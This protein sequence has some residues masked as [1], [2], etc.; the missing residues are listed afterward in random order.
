MTGR[1]NSAV[2][3]AGKIVAAD[4]NRLVTFDDSGRRTLFTRSTRVPSDVHPDADGGV[5]FLDSSGDQGEVKYVRDGR[6]RVVAVGDLQAL[7]LSTGAEGRV[8]VHGQARPHE[9]LPPSMSLLP[10]APQSRVSS[11]GRLAVEHADDRRPGRPVLQPRETAPVALRGLAVETRRELPFLV[12][13]GAD[14]TPH[15]AQGRAP[16]PAL[17]AAT[18][19][20]RTSSGPSNDTVD[21]GRACIVP[22][23]DPSTQVYQPHWK[24]VEWAAGNAVRGTLPQRP[25]NWKNSGLAAWSPQ[26]HFPRHELYRGAT[27]IAGGVIPPPIMLGILAQESNLWMASSHVIEG[28]TGNPLTGNFYGHARDPGN[29]GITDWTVRW[30]EADCGY[31]VGQITDWMNY[32]KPSPLPMEKAKAVAVDYATNIAAAVRILESKWNDLHSATEPM[33]KINNDNTDRIENWYFAVWSYNSGFYPHSNKYGN[34]PDG[35]PNNGAWGLGWFNNPINPRYPATRRMFMEI[36]A[37]A[38]HPQDWAYQ[39]KVIGWAAASITKTEGDSWQAGFQPAWWNPSAGN[40]APEN[41]AAAIPHG[42]NRQLFCLPSNECDPASAATPCRRADSKC[43]V[44]ESIT[45]KTDCNQRC[46]FWSYAYPAG[47]AEPPD[48]I[49]GGAADPFKPNCATTGLPGNALVVDDVA[50]NIPALRCDKTT[51]TNSGTLR[52]TFNEDLNRPGTYPARADFHQ[53]GNGFAG[54]QWFA[55]MRD[56]TSVNNASAMQ[57]TGTWTLNRELKQWARVLVHVPQRRAH[58]QQA[59]YTINLGNGTKKT[60]YI[61]QFTEENRWVSL[62]VYRFDG[63]PEV[64]LTTLALTRGGDGSDAV[65]WDAVAFQPL[66]AKPRHIVAALGDSYAS[67]EGAGTYYPE[68]DAN[69]GN[70][71]WNACRRSKNAWSRKLQLFGLSGALG[72]QSD[73][74][75]ADAELG[76]VA[77]SGAQTQNVRDWP[78]V[79]ERQPYG[80]GQFK[81]QNQVNSGVLDENTTLVTLTLGGNDNNAFASAVTTCAEGACEPALDPTFIPKYQALA[82]QM[83]PDLEQTVL[84]IAKK[85]P[86]AQILLLGYPKLIAPADCV[87]INSREAASLNQLAEYAN[88]KQAQM[89]A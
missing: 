54:H 63:T 13:P 22:R 88:S 77:C 82:N 36:Q 58:T 64:S 16:S 61:P 7:D 6:T 34:S 66:P 46:G 32:N 67:G 75:S 12:T 17:G 19:R 5:A 87:T 73:G 68:S 3:V 4:G 65:S 21:G 10:V 18:T 76:F 15:H 23:N 28:E 86:N 30:N 74:W 78:F 39:E 83:I 50:T 84:D 40:S 11:L 33:L 20:A 55:Y 48:A 9:A 57:V 49:P 45:W 89:A 51:W 62:G 14:V 26:G 37:D 29:G 60:R 25:A 53:L 27:K 38:T 81:E 70:S 2:P 69:H 41:R 52:F 44:H 80:E 42:N 43:W 71:D 35:T 47:S 1:R 72:A 56:T 8:F 85:A 31:G 79:L 59:P 24:Q